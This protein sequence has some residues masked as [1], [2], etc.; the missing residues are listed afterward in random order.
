MKPV[1]R[2]TWL[3][4]SGAAAA[5]SLSAPY[6]SRLAHAVP[7]TNKGDN[8]FSLG[9]ASGDPLSDSV[10][11]WTRLAPKPLEPG[12]GMPL[13]PVDVAWE[14]FE[15][16]KMTRIVR[17]GTAPAHPDWSHSVHVDVRGLNS[18]R[19]YW[20]RF[21]LGDQTSEIGRTRTAP[22]PGAAVEKLR[23]ASACCQKY[24]D[25]H[26][27]AYKHMRDEDLD[28]VLFLGDYIYEKEARLGKPRAHDL[29]LAETLE[30]YR[31]RYGLYKSDE[32][33]KAV[34]AAF[35][36]IVTW[37]DHEFA[38]DYA[39]DVDTPNGERSPEFLARRAN[40]YRAYYEHMPLRAAQKPKGPHLKLYRRFRFGDLAAV[41]VLDTRQYRTPQ[42]C[43]NKTRPVCAETDDPERTILGR[44]QK[45]W[46]L[47]GLANTPSRW[48]VIAQQVPMMQRNNPKGGVARYNMDK[49]DGYR[50]DR[51]DLLRFI[52]ERNIADV[53]ALS[54]DVHTNFA[55]DLKYDF[56]DPSSKTVGS[57][58]IGTSIASRG[59]GHD[60][61]KKGRKFLEDN[62]HLKFY[63]RQR[64]YLLNTVTPDSWRADFRVME[65]IS[66]PGAPVRTRASFM[67][68]AGRPG[69]KKLTG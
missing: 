43:G 37:D 62:G 1:S 53:I 9:V 4:R 51:N 44:E 15:D 66:R 30:H 17:Q 27:T 38:N 5:V 29:P 50:A 32:N 59:D 36:W 14:I 65:Y 61:S 6:V 20:Y 12:G 39:D 33:L 26:Y 22:A 69:L 42:P 45:A 58:F 55:G 23:F 16:E 60:L 3:K 46:L 25:G 47:D 41:H 31:A 7:G 28:F 40:A 49:W 63:N 34:H 19:W 54:G 13:K 2:R 56:D 10:V 64:G 48:T 21:R 11:L 52:G 8:L 57:E 35:P 24:E 18:A 68:E 67:V